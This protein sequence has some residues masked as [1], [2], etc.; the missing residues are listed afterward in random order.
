M[1]DSQGITGATTQHIEVEAPPEAHRVLQ[2]SWK[3][4]E[5]RAHS[6]LGFGVLRCKIWTLPVTIHRDSTILSIT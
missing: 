3:S 5:N 4:V 2:L 6:A 1:R